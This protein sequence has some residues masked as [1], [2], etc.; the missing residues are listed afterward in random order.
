MDLTAADWRRVVDINLNGA[1]IAAYR[2]DPG[3]LR[4]GRRQGLA[5]VA[6]AAIVA[7]GGGR[8]DYGLG[9]GGP[10]R[11]LN[12]AITKEF[13]PRRASGVTWS[14]LVD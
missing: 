1:F 3:H 12:R 4:A 5:L 14:I 7:G 13:R 10:G 6:S 2:R 8:A 11:G 9:Q